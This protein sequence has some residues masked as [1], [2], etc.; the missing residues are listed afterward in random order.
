[1][2][3]FV[4]YAV[5]TRICP[6]LFFVKTTFTTFN[7]RLQRLPSWSNSTNSPTSFGK[8][9]LA[10]YFPRPLLVVGSSGHKI[11]SST[12][13]TISSFNMPRRNIVFGWLPKTLCLATLKNNKR[14]V[15]R[16]LKKPWH[17][18]E[19]CC[20]ILQIHLRIIICNNDDTFFK[21]SWFSDL[22]FL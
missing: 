15:E 10:T 4:G 21:C 9:F 5:I 7:D 2:L 13:D 8:V 12:M 6:Y 14:K 18:R 20:A 17:L 11:V 19:K 16:E 1:M 22:Q 3:T